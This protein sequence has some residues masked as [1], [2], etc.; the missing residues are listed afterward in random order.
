MARWQRAHSN[1]V[2][3]GCPRAT[4]F[5]YLDGILSIVQRI[6][7]R[8]SDLGFILSRL[9]TDPQYTTPNWVFVQES[10]RHIQTALQVARGSQSDSD[11]EAFVAQA[12]TEPSPYVAELNT[13]GSLGGAK[14][15]GV[16]PEKSDHPGLHRISTNTGAKV[17][18]QGVPVNRRLT[19][20]EFIAYAQRT[21]CR[22][23]SNCE[24]I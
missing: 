16:T 17:A 14:P 22:Y 4:P 19:D 1:S 11:H 15:G 3:N 2:S 8:E 20:D 21:P 10:I 24:K 13:G 18:T 9:R 23:G 12:A 6:G 7:A 5:E